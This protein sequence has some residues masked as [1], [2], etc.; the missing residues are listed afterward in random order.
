MKK[1]FALSFLVFSAIANA[2]IKEGRVTYE[3]TTQNNFRIQGGD[4]EMA[5]RIPRTRTDHFELSFAKNQSLWKMLPDANEQANSFTDGNRVSFR[6]GMMGADDEVYYNFE[7]GKRLDKRELSGKNY[8]VDDSISKLNWKLTDETKTIS[9]FS[10]RKAT[11][12]RIGTRMAMTMENGEMKRQALPDTASIVAWF[13]PQIP[14]PAGPE[15]QGQLPGLIL[16]LDINN[17]RTVYKATEISQKVAT[18]KIKEPK[19][20]KKVTAAEFAKEREKLME[21][22]RQNLP[23][24]AN[25]RI[26]SN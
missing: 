13:T 8:L 7:T 21:E 18:D 14:V 22:M 1:I 15:F 16:E 23:P 12:Q 2:Q 11:A 24:G 5:N 17:G 26:N 6:F 3:R 20:G 25:I 9:G 19:G 10:V 4:P